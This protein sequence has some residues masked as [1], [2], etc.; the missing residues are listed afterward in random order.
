[1]SRTPFYWWGKRDT[2]AFLNLLRV[3]ELGHK[4]QTA[5][6][7]S[8]T[9]PMKKSLPFAYGSLV[10]WQK[11]RLWSEESGSGS[12]LCLP[13]VGVQGLQHLAELPFPSLEGQLVLPT[14]PPPTGLERTMH[15]ECVNSTPWR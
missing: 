11:L 14:G 1:M 5:Q 4:P 3:T 10:F 12:L 2:E 8:Q 9:P 6:P 15:K 13:Q 7:R